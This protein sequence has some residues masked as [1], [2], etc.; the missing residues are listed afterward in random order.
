MTLLRSIVK[1]K[2]NV[3]LVEAVEK[4][5]ESNGDKSDTYEAGSLVII[6]DAKKYRHF[7][8][9]LDEISKEK[10]HFLVKLNPPTA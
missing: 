4:V 1:A 8:E 10:E 7:I 2:A 9:V 6:A 5:Y 3:Q